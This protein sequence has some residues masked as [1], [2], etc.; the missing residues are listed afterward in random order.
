MADVP[1]TTTNRASPLLT[2]LLPITNND[3]SIDWENI[4]LAQLRAILGP[5]IGVA[6]AHDAQN[7]T[8]GTFVLASGGGSPLSVTFTIA[9]AQKV[10]VDFFAILSRLDGGAGRSRIQFTDG[11]GTKLWPLYVGSSAYQDMVYSYFVGEG[12]GHLLRARAAIQLAPGTYTIKVQQY[13]ALTNTTT[14]YYDRS[15]SVTYYEG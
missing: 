10:I 13:D 2:D 4:T 1:I 14:T 9:T 5:V 6:E 15:L 3:A 8:D 12:Q 11:G 7:A